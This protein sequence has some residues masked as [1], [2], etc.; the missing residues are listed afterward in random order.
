MSS[1]SS[2]NGSGSGYSMMMSSMKRPDPSQMTD[3]LFSKLDT[4][5]KGYL[6]KDDLQSA[7]S[8]LSDTGS[9][10]STNTS[11]AVDEM[12]KT[13]DSNSDDKITKDEMSNGLKKLVDALNSQMNEMRMNG[14]ASAG[15]GG[16]PPS[17][18]MP[19]PPTSVGR[20]EI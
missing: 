16:A 1:I 6:S 4:T 2:V 12:F 8:Q 7:L 13:L 3:K 20:R 15:E 17:G 11:T 10:S 18:G 14:N 9:A 5:N 19:P